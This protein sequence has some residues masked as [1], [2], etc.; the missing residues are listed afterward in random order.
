MG[1]AAEKKPFDVENLTLTG[2][3][4]RFTLRNDTNAVLIQAR[5]STDVKVSPESD[6]SRY[7]TIKADKGIALGSFNTNNQKLYFNGTIGVVV[8][9]QYV[10]LP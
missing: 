5:T 2:G 9:I 4:D 10:T 6:G 1:T 8:E 3:W 7:W